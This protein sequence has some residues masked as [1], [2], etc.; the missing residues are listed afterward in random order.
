MSDILR[1]A[2]PLTLSALLTACATAPI[3]TAHPP[4][5]EPPQVARTVSAPTPAPISPASPVPTDMWQRLRDSFAMSDCDADPAIHG[6]AQRYTRDPERFE[7][8]LSAV[9]PQLVYVQ[10]VAAR[11]KVAG[12]FALLPWV[13]SRFQ[14]AR[15]HNSRPTGMWQIVPA[16]AGAMGLHRTRG[17]DGRLDVPAATDAVMTLL[18]RYHDHFG[19]WRL[20]AYAYNAGEYSVRKLVRRHGMPP[21][22]P[23]LPRLPI[24][25]VTR[26]HLAKLLAIACVV[27][28]PA[29]F[30]VTLPTLPDEQQLVTVDVNHPISLA[31]AAVHA[32]MP[33]DTLQKLNAAFY[34]GRVDTR[35]SP[36]LLLPR[37]HAEQ[38]RS[39]LLE[40]AAD[41]PDAGLASAPLM[42]GLP[43]LLT[44]EAA[45]TPTGEARIPSERSHTRHT[46]VSAKAV[47]TVRSG[48]TL[49]Q[50]ARHYSVSVKQLQRWND[51][52]GGRIRP[53]QRLKVSPIT[54]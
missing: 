38:F 36:Y 15:G 2:F 41:G 30:H 33:T 39:A 20:A 31:Q 43:P 47:H 52:Q 19:D 26:E 22:H 40:Q 45:S 48:E 18:R 13:E 42:P 16:T 29:R 7:A 46:A 12:E 9:L 17:Y 32:G 34:N 11:Y 54:H 1:R 3:P 4:R 50:I 27:R 5:I 44:A 24:K 25:P 35:N 14:P 23:A 37:E 51:L 49:W 21:E 10:Q 53:G 8:Q 28:E 6:W